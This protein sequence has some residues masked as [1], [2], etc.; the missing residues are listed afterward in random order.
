LQEATHGAN[1]ATI[2]VR[3]VKL[4]RRGAV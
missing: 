4:A 3:L 1:G 2:V